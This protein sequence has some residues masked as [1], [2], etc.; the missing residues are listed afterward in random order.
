M[1]PAELG[2]VFKHFYA[3][4]LQK[5]GREYS[6]SSLTCIRAA[7]QR[8]LSGPPYNSVINVMADGHFKPANALINGAIRNQKRRGEDESTH[9]APISE[10]DVELM[11][12]SGV[13]SKN[14]PVSL[15]YK[16]FFELLLHFGRRGREGL[17]ELNKSDIIF[18]TDDEGVEF[19]T[20]KYN[21]HEKNHPGKNTHEAQHVQKMYATGGED[22]PVS[23]LKLYMSK[24]NPECESFF[25]Q[26]RGQEYLRSCIWYTKAPVGVN[27]LG[28]FMSLISKKA[29]LKNT[30]TNHCIRATTVT[31][32]RK[33]GVAPSDIVAVT[34][35]RSIA[36]IESYSSCTN[37]MQRT[38][39]DNYQKLQVYV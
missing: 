27:T 12:G 35:H 34:G 4:V 26:P 22:C 15:Q 36:S 32:L 23:S 14:D 16:T 25:Q 30:Y 9:H 5:D 28:N 39:Q 11:Y 18:K 19:A 6:R 10:K 24:L 2:V 13:L 29:G 7:I 17:R 21:P 37:D 31:S 1:E 3:E 33:A 8:H 38:C 20:L